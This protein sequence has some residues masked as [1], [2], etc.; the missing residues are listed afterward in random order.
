MN[1]CSSCFSSCFPST[2]ITFSATLTVISSGLNCCTSKLTRNVS[3]SKLTVDS[4]SLW[5]TAE[6]QGLKAVNNQNL[7]ELKSLTAPDVPVHLFK[8][9]NDDTLLHIAVRKKKY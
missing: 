6:L 3:L 7:E 2:V 9:S 5:E 1:P 8:Y 4:E